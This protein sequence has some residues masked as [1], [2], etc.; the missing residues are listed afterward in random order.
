MAVKESE[1]SKNASKSMKAGDAAYM[2]QVNTMNRGLLAADAKIKR[3]VAGREKT[4]T[5]AATIKV[6][7]GIQAE[8][9]RAL[10]ALFIRQGMEINKPIA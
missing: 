4:K 9:Q 2:K 5:T 8:S 1:S 7:L 6:Y 3:L 10:Q